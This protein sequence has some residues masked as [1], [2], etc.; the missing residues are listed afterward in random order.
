[1]NKVKIHKDQTITLQAGVL[2]EQAYRT[3]KGNHEQD[4][5]IGGQCPTVG[6]SGFTL[7]GGLS[8][9]SRSYGLAI[10]G[11]VEMKVVTAGGKL[12]VVT[13]DE[14]KDKKQDLFWA[15]RGGGGGNFGVT[16]SMR[17]RIHRLPNPTVVCGE[18]TWKMPQQ[19]RDFEQA[20]QAFNTMD[21]PDALTVDAI[22]SYTADGSLQA[23]M[24]TIFNGTMAECRKVLEPVLA[25][26]PADD[27]QSMHWTEW[28]KEEEG[29][30]QFSKVYHHHVSFV[31]GHGAITPEVTGRIFELID[32]SPALVDNPGGADG[33]GCHILWDHVGGAASRVERDET[34]YFW[35]DGVYVMTAKVQ[36][37]NPHQQAEAMAWAEKCKEVLTPY[38]LEQKAAYL[39][40]IDPTLKNWQAAYYGDNYSRLM[41]V[42]KQWDP[43]N[44]F[45]FPQSIELA[46]EPSPAKIWMN[47]GES[48][49][50]APAD[51]F[52]PSDEDELISI[53]DRA[54][55]RGINVRAVGSGHSWS[56]LVK[57]DGYLISMEKFKSIEV[58]PDKKSITFGAGVTVDEL[59]AQLIAN[60]VCVP[61]NVGHGV[62]E[63]TYGGVIA[64]GC[65]GSGIGFQ[66]I[67]DYVIAMR[68]IT[69]RGKTK[70]IDDRDEEV[71]NAARLSLGLFGMVTEITMRVEPEFNVKVEEFN[72]S[73]AEC[74]ATVKEF[75]LENEYAEVAW[76]PFTEQVNMQRANRT[77]EVA[78]RIGFEP[79]KTPFE[80]ALH[81]TIS[82][83]SVQALINSPDQTPSIMQTG[84]RIMPLYNYVSNITDYLHNADWSAIL[85]FK[86]ADIEISVEIDEEF[87]VVRKIIMITQEHVERWARAG[88][89]PFNGVL[90]FRFIKNSNATLSQARGNRMT[91]MVEFDAFYKT[92]LFEQFSG[93]LCQALM[94]EC[95]RARPHWAKGFQFMPDAVSYVRK[96][97]GS[98]L[99]QFM[100]ARE[101]ANVD[102]DNL[103][104]N[105]YLSKI[106]K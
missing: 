26:N 94:D 8:P 92:P 97:F 13:D 39:N 84:L 52:A 20:M 25:C 99:K 1:M 103:F 48:V 73:L 10:D 14:E 96:S 62:G 79:E 70:V 91:A 64:T 29:F 19:R 2:W 106:F 71:L 3:L 18:L 5:I 28:E 76:V 95:P 77:Q 51:Q 34:A 66:S 83:T 40:Y 49:V 78:T 44:F 86:V 35:R 33:N 69:S 90:G 17:C 58:A 27:L 93:E 102:P 105:R 6:V 55:K 63:A 41:H 22:W 60:G 104:M 80:S 43:T 59:A 67:S 23:Q 36:W 11:L 31:L 82:A 32:S 81:N 12:V 75:V 56:P 98:Q 37:S 47:W 7:G 45:Y 89:Y 100:K 30:D 24:T 54:R 16:T 57:T 87:E 85:G 15:L 46:D 42:K 53:I 65:H 101:K 68:V 38:T 4:I 61:T 50:C 9:F 88:H 21:V 72:M 74:L